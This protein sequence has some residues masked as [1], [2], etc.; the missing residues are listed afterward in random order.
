VDERGLLS[1]IVA[2]NSRLAGV[3]KHIGALIELKLDVAAS[4]GAGC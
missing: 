4:L 3:S 2:S 1:R